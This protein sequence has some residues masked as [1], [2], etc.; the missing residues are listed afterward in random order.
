[1][2]NGLVAV[3]SARSPSPGPRERRSTSSEPRL[4]R[5]HVPRVRGDTRGAGPWGR[6]CPQPECPARA[7][8]GAPGTL[9]A[10]VRPGT[11]CGRTGGADRPVFRI[12][13][14]Q[15]PT[16]APPA[17]P[18]PPGRGRM[19]P[20]KSGDLG[21]WDSGDLPRAPAHAHSGR[22]TGTNDSKQSHA[23]WPESIAKPIPPSGGF[24]LS[25]SVRLS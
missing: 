8:S 19:A 3:V 11:Q 23:C 1:M 18:T 6:P 12:P 7:H 24:S 14:F 17:P 13:D 10:L 21:T 4:L 22:S 25:S 9:R 16:H 5:S 15:V 20:V 2:L